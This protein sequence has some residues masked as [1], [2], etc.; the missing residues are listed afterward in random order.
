ML[1][2]EEKLDLVI[3]ALAANKSAGSNL[4]MSTNTGKWTRR[5]MKEVPSIYCYALLMH[6]TNKEAFPVSLEYLSKCVDVESDPIDGKIRPELG[7][8]FGIVLEAGFG[9]RLSAMSSLMTKD[10]SSNI[11][12]KRNHT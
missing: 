10:A 1:R 5:V 2:L 6:Y 12:V 8:T 3:S 11:N 9:I 4:T 7:K